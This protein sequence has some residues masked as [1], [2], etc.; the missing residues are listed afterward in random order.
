MSIRVTALLVDIPNVRPYGWTPRPGRALSKD[1]TVQGHEFDFMVELEFSKFTKF[2]FGEA[3]DFDLEMLSWGERIR[4]YAPDPYPTGIADPES[5]TDNM[6]RQ[7]GLKWKFVYEDVV[8][9]ASAERRGTVKTVQDGWYGDPGWW[10]PWYIRAWRDVHEPLILGTRPVD[11]DA[12]KN[13]E[14]DKTAKGQAKSKLAIQLA[15][16]KHFMDGKTTLKTIMTDRPGLT[17]K[18]KIDDG[19]KQQTGGGGMSTLARQTRRRVVHFTLGLT[20]LGKLATATQVLETVG[21]IPTINKFMVPGCTLQD[22][23]DEALLAKWRREMDKANI[24][25][26]SLAK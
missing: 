4:W 20:K 16:A 18:S 13:K 22:S 21:G 1:D 5:Y 14:K 8:D 3:L 6:G 2:G 15:V 23:E 9:F 26:F 17:K 19:S 11:F 7:P 25:N 10:D 24:N 12:I